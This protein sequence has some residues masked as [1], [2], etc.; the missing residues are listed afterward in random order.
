MG[1]RVKKTAY[2]AGIVLFWLILWQLLTLWVGNKI[3]LAGPLETF[4]AL[5]GY[6]VQLTFWRTVV[7]SL[8]RIG[9]GFLAG[10]GVGLCLAVL[11]ARWKF[12]EE[13]LS[14]LMSLLK[15]VPVAS[16]VV[17]FLIWWR[18]N[19]LATAISFSVVMPN[20][21]FST[22]EGLRS[23][24]Q[25]LLEMA[26]VYRVPLWNRFF[27]IYRPALKPFLDNSIKIA[28]GMSWKSGVAAEVIG[29]PAYSVGEKLYMSKIYLD[30]EG[31]LAWSAVVIL[32][33]MLCEKAV[34]FGWDRFQRWE[35]SCRPAGKAAE[36]PAD[37]GGQAVLELKNVSKSYEGKEILKDFSAVYK[38]GETAYFT[39]P[40]G[41]GKTTLFRLI[42]GL[43]KPDGGRISNQTSLTF[44]FQEDRLLESYSALKNVELVTGDRE[45]AGQHLRCLLEEEDLLKPCRDLSGGMK[46]RVAIARAF[47]AQ[48]GITLLDEPYTGLDGPNRERVRAYIEQFGKGRT[49]LVAT[50]ITDASKPKQPT[51]P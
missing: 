15:A 26:G 20:L 40:S 50:H 48:A 10:C 30:T 5:L 8:L 18:S 44:V 14:P 7:C 24:D 39:G 4:G 23:T 43:E 1:K 19:V 46:R 36:M 12:S 13:L 33:S 47:A 6:L 21:Y 11:S 9:A 16:F 31:V 29:T 42:A 27:Y 41:S 17:L 45:R 49:L 25:K 35:P 22:L 51:A 3:L 2:R 28:V 32:T 34:L 37:A 38:A